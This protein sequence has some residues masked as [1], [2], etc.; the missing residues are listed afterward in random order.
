MKQRN[1]LA[2]AAVLTCTA[3][4]TAGCGGGS[5]SNEA[6]SAL[7][8]R[9][10]ITYVAGKDE[11]GVTPKII[12]AWNKTHPDEQVRFIELS[13]SADD[14]RQQMVQNAQTK[15]DAFTVLEID[16][17]WTT[18][19]SANRWI[20]ELPKEQFGIDKLVPTTVET[21]LYR[22]RLY[23]VPATSDGAM[24]YFRKDLLA[25]AGVQPPKTWDEMRQACDKV[26]ALPEA[27]GMSCYAGQF[28]KYEGLTVNFA[29]AVHGAGGVVTD[30]NGKPHV[31]TPEAKRGL[32]A[33]VEGF[34][35]GMI[36]RD[37]ITFKEAETR[38]AFMDGKV[39]FSRAW[40]NQYSHAS[41]TDGS[42]PVADKFDVAPLPGVA[43]PG[44]SS[45]GGHSLA[46]SS[47]AKNKATAVDFIKFATAP[48]Q[49]RLR[50]D[51][52][53]LAPTAR[54]LYED[55]ALQ[56]K[57]PYLPLLEKSIEGAEPRPR[58][59]KYGEV[60]DAIQEN[61]YAAL[62]GEKSSEQA[63]ADLQAQLEAL[64]GQQ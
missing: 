24:L 62:R 22:D 60:T 52:G 57:Y 14:Q 7:E 33:L 39:V 12:E 49:Q 43:G 23:G 59:I 61:V 40:P 51:V 56:A 9:G 37:G 48:E 4:L 64:T 36:P 30:E 58:V 20:T 63:L 38:R 25:K 47:F 44:V 29:E 21:A 10:P 17:V 55:P 5:S 6:S 32:D 41:A 27:A 31:N 45:L 54:E 28:E 46:I 42:S 35:S 26:K 16:N 50:L 53:S 15:S 1:R 19:F 11:E 13:S 3:A 18:E 2:I 34:N 8:G